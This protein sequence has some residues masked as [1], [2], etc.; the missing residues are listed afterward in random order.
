MEWNFDAMAWTIFPAQLCSSINGNR[1]TDGVKHLSYQ[2]IGAIIDFRCA[3][4]DFNYDEDILLSLT[5]KVLVS[6]LTSASSFL[7]LS[8]RASVMNIC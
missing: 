1:K 4:I 6:A 3:I 8:S 7:V 2:I 5:M